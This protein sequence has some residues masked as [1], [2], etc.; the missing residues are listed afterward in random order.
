VYD[1]LAVVP[2][3]IANAVCSLRKAVIVDGRVIVVYLRI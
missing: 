3:G 1:I 2:P